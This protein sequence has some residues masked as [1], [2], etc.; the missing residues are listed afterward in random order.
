MRFKKFFETIYK[1]HARKTY[2]A[3][4]YRQLRGRFARSFVTSLGPMLMSSITPEEAST[5][6][7]S[8]QKEHSLRDASMA[9]NRQLLLAI[10]KLA[11]LEGIVSRNII[12]DTIKYSFRPKK[13][14]DT[15]TK[16]ELHRLL[17]FLKQSKSPWHYIY[18][19]ACYTGMRYSE[20][21]ELKWEDIVEE[22]KAF[23]VRRSRSAKVKEVRQTKTGKLRLVPI[24]PYIRDLLVELGFR[25]EEYIL[26][27]APKFVQ[28]HAASVLKEHAQA[29][30]LPLIRFHDL[31]AFFATELLSKG[32][33]ITKVMKICGWS[34]L[35]TAN[36][37]MR[38]ASIDIEG[39]TDCLG[40]AI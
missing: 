9:K 1:P 11:L 22:G 39:V 23:K 2:A 3:T 38:M 14:Y 30:N 24:N 15:L 34:T 36:R 35:A 40:A 17:S 10:F 4:T 16:E 25:N 29:L 7:R 19:F 33:P 6:L 18:A 37:Y 5:F 32:I 28:G 26:P 12:H 13:D 20:L 27:R 8:Y 21:L 31:R